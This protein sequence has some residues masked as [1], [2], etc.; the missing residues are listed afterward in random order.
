MQAATEEDVDRAVRAAYAAMRNPE[1]K[2]MTGPDRGRLLYKLA[3]LIEEN[4]K[5]LATIDAWDNG[6]AP[7]PSLHTPSLS[8][9]PPS[10]KKRSYPLPP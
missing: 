10:A 5:L 4:L 7:P 6:T 2:Y 1:W 3:D 8:L 9:P